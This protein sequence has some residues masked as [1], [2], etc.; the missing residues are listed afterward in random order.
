MTLQITILSMSGAPIPELPSHI[1]PGA[2]SDAAAFRVT[3]GTPPSRTVMYRLL[4]VENE[5]AYLVEYDQAT[6]EG[7]FV[8]V[9]GDAP[10]AGTVIDLDT[11]ETTEP[12]GSQAIGADSATEAYRTLTVEA[13]YDELVWHD[14]YFA[15]SDDGSEYRRGEQA[16]ARLDAIAKL[17]GPDHAALYDAFK[18]HHFSGKPWGTAQWDKP[19]RPVSG[20]LVL[21][22]APVMPA[23]PVTT[24]APS[25][26]SASLGTHAE[27]SKMAG[28]T[29]QSF[30]VPNEVDSPA[31]AP[32]PHATAVGSAETEPLIAAA[33]AWREAHERLEK[34][35]YAALCE[36]VSVR[37]L[38]WLR[39]DRAHADALAQARDQKARCEDGLALAVACLTTTR[40]LDHV[41]AAHRYGITAQGSIPCER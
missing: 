5:D 39:G 37:M 30:D 23:S 17:S 22:D 9:D 28:R 14:W 26:A 41:L 11:G 10:A 13:F 21:P 25:S 4:E 35:E 2:G 29:D 20:V 8:V 27:V 18:R 31:M 3:H 24:L 12:A 38:R 40:H 19:K 1:F 34:L 15:Y 6:G 36:S 7:S 16:E 33:Q 32:P